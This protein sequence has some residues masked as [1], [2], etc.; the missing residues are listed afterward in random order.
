MS[1]LVRMLGET[2]VI[3]HDQND[4]PLFEALVQA[5]IPRTQIVMAY[6]GEPVP[7]SASCGDVGQ[8]RLVN[9]LS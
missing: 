6:A 9:A 1:L 4:K 7:E 5:G 3:E 8:Y 2:I